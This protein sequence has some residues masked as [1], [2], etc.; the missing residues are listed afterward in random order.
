LW[1]RESDV[2]LWDTAGRYDTRDR[3]SSLTAHTHAA[4][5]QDLWAEGILSIGE[6]KVA[7]GLV[8]LVDEYAM[9][10]ERNATLDKQYG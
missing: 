3:S 8:S 4:D 9:V 7:F 6:L 1:R 10:N 2:R 5:F